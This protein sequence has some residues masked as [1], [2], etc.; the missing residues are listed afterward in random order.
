P[1]SQASGASRLSWQGMKAANPNLMPEDFD[2]LRKIQAAT[3]A[4][5]DPPPVPEEIACR[6]RAFGLVTP[7]S[8]GGLAITDRGRGVLLEQDMRDA[9]DR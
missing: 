6:L 5:R 3:D 1:T 4:T 7:A 2:E 9:E 8:S